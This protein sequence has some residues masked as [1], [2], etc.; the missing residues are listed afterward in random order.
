MEYTSG[1]SSWARAFRRLGSAMLPR[2]H[3]K[4]GFAWSVLTP[5]VLAAAGMLFSLT[6]ATAQGTD[7]RED[8]RPELT[9]LISERKQE[10]AAGRD[11]AGRLRAAI[12]AQQQQQAGADDRVDAQ[13]RRGNDQQAAAGLTAVHGPGVVVVLDDAPRRPDGSRPAGATPDDLVVHQQDVQA[14]V[15]ALWAGGAE[16]MTLMGVRVIATSAVRCVGNTLLLDGQVYSPPFEIA[17]I[18]DQAR[19]QHS[20]DE[21]EGVRLFK[22]AADNFGLGYQVRVEADVQAGAYDGSTALRSARTGS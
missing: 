9:N 17:A 14:V 20:L 4:H 16:A 6:A 1:D 15:N 21:A 12:D 11:R 8:R 7:L 13:R 3:R 18:G 2:R 22:E 19:L 10:I 5:V